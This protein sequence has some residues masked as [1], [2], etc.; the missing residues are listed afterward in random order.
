VG[1]FLYGVGAGF[2][3][4]FRTVGGFLGSGYGSVFG[5]FAGFFQ[6]LSDLG[7]Q[8]RASYQEYRSGNDGFHLFDPLFTKM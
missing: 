8:R 1:A 5:V 2:V 7:K 3:D 6:I 4:L